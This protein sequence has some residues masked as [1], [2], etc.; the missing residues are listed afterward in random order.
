MRIMRAHQRR[1]IDCHGMAH[2]LECIGGC[3][4]R[5]TQD[6]HENELARMHCVEVKGK[7]VSVVVYESEAMSKNR[8]RGTRVYTQTRVGNT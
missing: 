5:L 8:K 4:Q 1:L 7:R 3:T 2:L 6:Q